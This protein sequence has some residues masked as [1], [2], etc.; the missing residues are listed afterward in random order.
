MCD[1]CEGGAADLV[2]NLNNRNVGGDIDEETG[3]M[4]FYVGKQWMGS[5]VVHFCP[6]CGKPVG[7]NRRLYENNT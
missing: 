4:N 3:V 6:M 7:N 5:R 2:Y 1:W